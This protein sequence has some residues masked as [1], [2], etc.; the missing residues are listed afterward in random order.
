[1]EKD[2]KGLVRTVMMAMRPRYAREKSLPYKSNKVK[3]LKLA[4]Q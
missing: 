2:E 3:N 1:V 4:V